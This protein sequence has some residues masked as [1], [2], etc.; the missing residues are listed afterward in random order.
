M[1]GGS[2]N[3]SRGYSA[4]LLRVD[5]TL[6]SGKLQLCLGDSSGDD[7]FAPTKIHVRGQASMIFPILVQL[8]GD[9]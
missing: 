7:Y 3:V 9:A 6:K 2:A 1:L 8:A 4:H 5:F